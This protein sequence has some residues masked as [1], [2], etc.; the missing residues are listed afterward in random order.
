MR[1]ACT[2][3]QGNQDAPNAYLTDTYRS[4]RDDTPDGLYV[5]G[6]GYRAALPT[7]ALLRSH[8]TGAWVETRFHAPS[9]S[10]TP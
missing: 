7:G 3:A 10:L 6:G 5:S 8:Q 1:R 9:L 4:V 2:R